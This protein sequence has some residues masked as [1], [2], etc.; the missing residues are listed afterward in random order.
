[1]LTY[2]IKAKPEEVFVFVYKFEKKKFRKEF[3]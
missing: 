1:M 3:P 2:K